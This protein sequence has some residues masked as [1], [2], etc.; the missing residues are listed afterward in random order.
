LIDLN[1]EIFAISEDLANA[2]SASKPDPHAL[3]M[4]A[5]EYEAKRSRIK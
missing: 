2:F 4:K 3:Y 5:Q 1:E